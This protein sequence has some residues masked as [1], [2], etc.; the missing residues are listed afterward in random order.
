MMWLL[1]LL[2]KV[3]RELLLLLTLVFLALAVRCVTQ[4]EGH[5]DHVLF[6]ILQALAATRKTLLVPAC[7]AK[8]SV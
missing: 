4:A 3:Q 7:C 6:H 1:L 8:E 2:Q 5:G